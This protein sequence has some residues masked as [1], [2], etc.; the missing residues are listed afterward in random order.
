MRLKKD[1]DYMNDF[2]KHLLTTS[3][4][5]IYVGLDGIGRPIKRNKALSKWFRNALND[6]VYVFEDAC[7]IYFSDASS[8]FA[9]KYMD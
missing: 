1:G 7:Y 3:K 9:C 6:F 5:F 4:K 2:N 8:T